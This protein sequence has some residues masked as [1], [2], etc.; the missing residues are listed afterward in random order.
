MTDLTDL[1]IRQTVFADASLDVH[2]RLAQLRSWK[3]AWQQEDDFLLQKVRHLSPNRALELQQ[4][5][6]IANLRRQLY[7]RLV[8][9][10]LELPA[11]MVKTTG[12]QAMRQKLTV[13]FAGLSQT[14]RLLWL[15]NFLF[16]LT[17]DLRQINDKITLVRDYQAFGQRRNFLL[18]GPSG[19]GKTTYLNWVALNHSPTVEPERNYVPIVKIDAPVNNRTTNP[20]L[21]RIIL[22]CGM[23]YTQADTDE[24]LLMKVI[25]FVQQCGVDTLI[26]DEIEHITRHE[27]R[28]RLL[29]ISNLTQ[30]LTIICAA[31]HPQRWVEGDPEV[32]GRWNDEFLLQPYTG[33]RLSQLLAFLELLL[34]FT[35]P[36]SLASYEIK[37]GPGQRQTVAGPAQLIEQY[38][39]GILRD[40]MVLIMDASQ[41]A[42]QQN[43]SHLSPS[44]LEQTWQ[45]IQTNQVTDLLAILH[46]NGGQL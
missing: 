36:S 21:Q 45:D 29:E 1:V 13:Q 6:Q 8:K 12:Y 34:P 11:E 41:R 33:Q 22:A 17:P 25:L 30:G 26:V 42:I 2:H 10:P 40:I 3:T 5:A 16:I 15:N 31:C 46:R 20:L 32:A 14:E 39:G 27:I 28:R 35:Q 23:N 38:T 19:T 7:L 18:G 44:L 4:A 9:Q 43:R 24:V 37:I